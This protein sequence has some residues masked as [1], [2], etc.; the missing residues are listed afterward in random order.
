MTTERQ[1]RA[2]RS[3]RAPIELTTSRLARQLRSAPA[4][5]SNA[6]SIAGYLGASD[7]ADHVRL[8][9]DPADAKLAEIAKADIVHLDDD[10]HDAIGG[11][12]RLLVETD[13]DRWSRRDHR[14]PDAGRDAQRW[15]DRP[16]FANMVSEDMVVSSQ[17]AD[18]GAIMSDLTGW[19]RR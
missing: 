13:C 10:V 18:S 17:T 14:Q 5:R 6:V 4:T 1:A 11:G 9:V 15:P 12:R 8:Y 19:A 3:H 7:H 2:G 16:L